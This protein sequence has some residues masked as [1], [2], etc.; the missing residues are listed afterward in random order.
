MERY[1]VRMTEV[2][3]A[4]YFDYRVVIDDIVIIVSISLN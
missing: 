4:H 2:T 1:L 3:K